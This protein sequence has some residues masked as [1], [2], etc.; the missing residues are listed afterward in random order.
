[1]SHIQND[2][3]DLADA[4]AGADRDA[5]A[6]LREIIAALDIESE[7]SYR[8]NKQPQAVRPARPA[9]KPPL[10]TELANVLYAHF[11]TRSGGNP[12]SHDELADRT[13]VAALSAANSGKGT[14]EPGWQI[15]G[16][17]EEGR[18]P[19]RKQGLTL[20]VTH[21]QL[22]SR[23]ASLRPGTRC[24]IRVGKELREMMTGFYIAIGNGDERDEQDEEDRL[25]RLYFHISAQ[26]APAL[27]AA[28]TNTL[29]RVQIAFRA[30]VL[31]HHSGYPRADAGVLYLD[32]RQHLRA[33][34]LLPGIYEQ[35]R[36][37]LG[38]TEPRF[39][40]RMAP[41]LGL[42]E[43]PGTEES[44]GQHRCRLVAEGLWAAFKA[45][46]HTPEARLAAVCATLEQAGLSPQRPYLQPGSVD[47][48][49]P[50][51]L[52]AAQ[53]QPQPQ[54]R[55]QAPRAPSAGRPYGQRSS[56]HRRKR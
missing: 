5:L 26:G 3:A 1:M 25:V 17:A 4:A 16:E 39:T 48:Y 44:F 21:E 51:G 15:Q 10:V 18:I 46:S 38:P 22:R 43:D 45:G 11:Y 23:G 36:A 12:R 8:L 20:W 49:A 29:N 31:N 33:A 37:H 7:S 28:I 42:A 41:G 52:S 27:I 2:L 6:D 54:A 9:E 30:K 14:W 50:L 32:R 19:V 47:D 24:R 34:P 56:Q 13:L 35:V 40:K 53:P 55:P